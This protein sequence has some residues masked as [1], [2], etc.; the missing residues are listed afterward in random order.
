MLKFNILCV[1]VVLT[2]APVTF[3]AELSETGE[4]LDGVA[5]IVNE[6]VVLKS[7]LTSQIATIIRERA[8]AQGMQLPPPEILEEQMLERLILTEIQLQRADRI[9]L[10]ISDEILNRQ[11]ASIAQGNNVAFEDMPR[12]LAQDGIDYASFGGRSVKNSRSS[13]CDAS[14]LASA[15]TFPSAKSSSALLISKAML[16]PIQNTNFRTYS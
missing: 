8:A 6:G 4:F 11:I 5:A 7:Q 1:T 3:A 12:L 13:N 16:S 10:D 15:S 14:R 2:V 9:G